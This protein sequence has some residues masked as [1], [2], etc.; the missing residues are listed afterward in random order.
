MDEQNDAHKSMILVEPRVLI[1]GIYIGSYITSEY[2]MKFNLER[3]PYILSRGPAKRHTQEHHSS[4]ASC[5]F[6]LVYFS[7]SNLKTTPCIHLDEDIY[8]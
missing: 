1:E 7:S 4:R 8:Y 2:N 6:D 3:K 5:C